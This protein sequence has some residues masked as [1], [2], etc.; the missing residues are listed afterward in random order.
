MIHDF[1]L[2]TFG[3]TTES[4]AKWIQAGQ[5]GLWRQTGALNDLALEA[6]TSGQGLGEALGQLVE[7]A[8]PLHAELSLAAAG[9]R[10]GV[11]MT[12]HVGIGNDIIH[13]HPNFDAAAWGQASDTDFLIFTR[14]VQDLAGGVFLNVGTAVTGPEVFLKA[15]SMVR[16][17]ARQREE[18]V[19]GFS[20]AVFDL[21][22]LPADWR[23]GPPGKEHP[24]Y[25]FRPWKTILSRT[26]ADGGT[27][28]FFCGDH[29]QTL[30][31]LWHRL[32]AK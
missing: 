11:P 23:G 20:T 26:V 14:S 9:W 7:E 15:L 22:P 5:F 12:V 30:P 17:V 19:R 13:A 29:R 3:G 16:N 8:R 31:T 25:Y 24:Q 27:S 18:S 28:Y 10:A 32:T 6:A 1:E 2:A 21:V 4:V